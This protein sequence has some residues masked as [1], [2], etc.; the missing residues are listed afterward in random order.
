KN[1]TVQHSTVQ[2]TGRHAFSCTG[3]RNM[4]VRD[5]TITNV[6]YHGVD[7][8][9]EAQAWTGDIT[10][11]RNTYSKVRLS[12]LSAITGTG[13]SLGPFVVRGNV[14]TDWP[15]PCQYPIAVGQPGLP[16]RSVTIAD[17][18]VRALGTGIYVSAPHADV[19]GNVAEFRPTGCG[20]SAG[21]T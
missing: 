9:V 13:T 15:S 10:L 20:P 5:N 8:E 7:V 21:V 2:T 12:M 6:G 1:V 18:K 11:E 3:C 14:Q 19:T 4:V 17:N 16:Y